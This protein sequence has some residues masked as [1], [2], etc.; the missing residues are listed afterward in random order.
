VTELNSAYERWVEGGNLGIPF[1]WPKKLR[2]KPVEG[3]NGIYEL[4]WSFAGPD[5]RA[6][7]E[8]IDVEGEPG[9]RWRRIGGHEI[10]SDP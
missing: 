3:R 6:T 8:Y 1:P 9:I 10:F 4:T 5:G 7:F 2:I